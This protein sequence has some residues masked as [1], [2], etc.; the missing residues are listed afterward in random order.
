MAKIILLCGKICSGKSHYAK[1]LVEEQNA[2]LLSCDDITLMVDE[3]AS[4]DFDK[5][6]SLVKVYLSEKAVEIASKGVN[7]IMDFGCWSREDRKATKDFFALHGLETELH[8]VHIS[9][10]DWKMNIEQ[11]R[12]KVQ[13]G[14]E[15]GY[16]LDEG[17]LKKMLE[18][19][20][21]P[22]DDEIDVLYENTRKQLKIS[23]VAL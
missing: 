23:E 5:F 2:V 13:N 20:D 17:L 19:F 22:S 6:A 18:S 10:A 16:V 4:Y 9:D 1:K 14:E 12:V 7:V 8:F 21:E 11:R 3:V 15:K